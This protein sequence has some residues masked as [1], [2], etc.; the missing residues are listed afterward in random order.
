MSCSKNISNLRVFHGFPWVFHGFP[1]KNPRV[2]RHRPGPT[3]RFWPEPLPAAAASGAAAPARA[4]GGRP[5]GRGAWAPGERHD[6]AG[7]RMGWGDGAVGKGGGFRSHGY[8]KWLVYG[9]YMV[10][11]QWF[12]LIVINNRI[13][14][15]I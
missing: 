2:S 4:P 8:P 12:P 15:D 14:W 5:G 9:E 1:I 3:R 6:A 10:G 13:E 11:L 7:A